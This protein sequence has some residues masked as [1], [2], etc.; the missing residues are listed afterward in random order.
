LKTPG[1]DTLAD[2]NKLLTLITQLAPI[3]AS[4]TPKA[5]EVADIAGIVAQLL[6]YIQQQS[7]MTTD[8]I[9]NRAGTTLD[10]NEK[11]LLAD[12]ARLQQGGGN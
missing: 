6:A 8:E 3:A 2:I 5:S 10:D 12:L 1:G 7:G 11:V 4:F 9:L